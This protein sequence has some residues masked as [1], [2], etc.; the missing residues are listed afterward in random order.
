MS[1]TA[2]DVAGTIADTALQMAPIALAAMAASNPTDAAIAAMVPV[3][4][5]IIQQAASQQASGA[6][7]GA[8]LVAKCKSLATTLEATQAAWD[9]FAASKGVTAT[10]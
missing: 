5:N 7:T 1:A 8:E 3:V 10:P 2:Q 4:T 9:Q 6:M